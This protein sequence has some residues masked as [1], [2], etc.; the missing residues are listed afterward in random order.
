[1]ESFQMNATMPLIIQTRS[2]MGESD[3]YMKAKQLAYQ[4]SRKV[5]C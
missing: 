4:A 5:F 3:Y 1:M 2:A